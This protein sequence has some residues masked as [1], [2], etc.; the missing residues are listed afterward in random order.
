M[1]GFN[2]YSVSLGQC[3]PTLNLQQSPAE[4]PDSECYTEGTSYNLYD[5]NIVRDMRLTPW[6]SDSHMLPFEIGPIGSLP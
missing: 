5:W 1:C 2:N 3:N 6:S 4:A